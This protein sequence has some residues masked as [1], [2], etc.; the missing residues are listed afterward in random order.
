MPF[1][2]PILAHVAG[3]PVEETLLYAAPVATLCAGAAS[4]RLAR[5]WRTVRGGRDRPA[6]PTPTS[7]SAASE[8]PV[9]RS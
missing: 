7:V 9:E 2:F 8:S 5:A 3:L 6:S 1:G 4:A